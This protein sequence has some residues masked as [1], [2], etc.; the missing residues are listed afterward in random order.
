MWLDALSKGWESDSAVDKQDSLLSFEIVLPAGRS[1]P[2]SRAAAGE[3]EYKACY[4]T[5]GI[6]Y[7][8][9]VKMCQLNVRNL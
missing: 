8:I 4:V 6:L 2:G 7:G 3:F 5:H 9:V 1:T